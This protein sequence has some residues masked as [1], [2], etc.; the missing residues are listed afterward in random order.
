MNGVKKAKS[1]KKFIMDDK[2]FLVANQLENTNVRSLY[3]NK[4]QLFFF[5]KNTRSMDT[6]HDC[7]FD[8]HAV[9]RTLNSP[10]LFPIRTPNKRTNSNS[11][12]FF[13]RHFNSFVVHIN[14]IEIS[15]RNIPDE[16]HDT[17]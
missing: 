15:L 4:F 5:S 14:F 10:D 11:V 17:S 12:A 9:D 8:R 6:C 13:R 3:V 2:H 7:L 16:L 1:F